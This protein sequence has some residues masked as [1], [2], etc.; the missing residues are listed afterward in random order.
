VAAVSS[1][2]PVIR[3]NL[4][5][6]RLGAGFAGGVKFVLSLPGWLLHWRPRLVGGGGEPCDGAARRGSRCYSFS[7]WV[8]PSD[9]SS[10]ASRIAVDGGASASGAFG[11]F[12]FSPAA[13]LPILFLGWDSS[14]LMMVLAVATATSFP[15]RRLLRL[16]WRWTLY[17]PSTGH[18]LVATDRSSSMV[19]LG[20]DLSADYCCG[21]SSRF[22][23]S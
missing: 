5:V 8:S 14:V 9:S 12:L 18:K 13:V 15:N 11:A 22:E 23:A 19:R 7:R 6:L 21:C 1:L 3:R 4:L 16:R 10:A 17:S 2:S 20:G